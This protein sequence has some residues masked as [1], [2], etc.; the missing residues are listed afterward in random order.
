MLFSAS[1]MAS[2]PDRPP[3]E[4]RAG[5]T[6]RGWGVGMEMLWGQKEV[7]D[8]KRARGEQ[9]SGGRKRDQGG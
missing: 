7:E 1:G 4:K 2:A 5:G 3:C 8:G 6:R 9:K